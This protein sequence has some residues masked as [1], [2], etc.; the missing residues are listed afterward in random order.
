MELQRLGD[1]KLR[2]SFKSIHRSTT[3]EEIIDI[4]S[5]HTVLPEFLHAHAFT[6]DAFVVANRVPHEMKEEILSVLLC[7]FHILRWGL[8]DFAPF[9]DDPEDVVNLPFDHPLEWDDVP[10]LRRY[11]N[12][13]LGGVYD[14]EWLVIYWSRQLE[15]HDANNN[16]L[17]PSYPRD[18][19]NRLFY[20]EEV[21]EVCDLLQFRWKLEHQTQDL[22]KA[23]PALFSLVY[24][25]VGFDTLSTVYRALLLYQADPDH[26]KPST[27]PAIRAILEDLVSRHP[28]MFAGLRSGFF[29]SGMKDPVYRPECVLNHFLLRRLYFLHPMD[30]DPM[31]GDNL[32][33]LDQ[34]A[35]V[36]L[37]NRVRQHIFA[38]NQGAY[39]IQYDLHP[40]TM[41]SMPKT[42]HF[43]WFYKS[44]V[45]GTLVLARKA[46]YIRLLDE[47]SKALLC[48]NIPLSSST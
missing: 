6:R 4:V 34:H 46:G 28:R 39:I 25:P 40:K 38:A 42:V 24:D 18:L 20:P 41:K 35:L 26:H 2:V 11:S 14:P 27:K 7:W 19:M 17:L 9:P 45:D 8:R 16:A 43:S 32:F 22:K 47:V 15:N 33:H 13:R 30:I 37:E 1:G 29:F 21:R 48:Q 5:N 3:T 31:S 36:F 10:P 23:S 44:A 12:K